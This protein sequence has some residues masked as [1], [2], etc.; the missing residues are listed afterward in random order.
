M[1]AYRAGALSAS[2]IILT[3]AASSASATDVLDQQ[4]TDTSR[5]MAAFSDTD[6]A[7]SFT[8]TAG[9]VS[10]GGIYV[11]PPTNSGA[12]NGTIDF[13]LWTALPNAA[14]AAE[15]AHGST[16]VSAGNQ[17]IDTF[18]TPVAVTFGQTYYLTFSSGTAYS[19]G[20][21]TTNL[22][23]GGQLYD[24]PG[25]YSF[26]TYDF[27]FRTYTSTTFGSPAPEP[28]AWLLM[29]S[30]LGMVGAVTRRR[31]RDTAISA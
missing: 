15:L 12:T 7:Q 17:W 6:A 5:D 4:Q 31:A 9:N 26:P 29:I 20:G 22:Y 10:G 1:T 27:A 14:G 2:L 13:G 3:L 21:N 30:G 19:V 28:A 11:K 23:A 8:P 25:Y 16:A 18:W 24:L